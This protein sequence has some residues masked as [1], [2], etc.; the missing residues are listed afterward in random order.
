MSAAKVDL[1]IEKGV[2]FSCTF[3]WLDSDGTATNITSYTAKFTIRS[4]ETGKVI[5]DSSDN[6]TLTLGDAAGT[7]VVALTATETQALDFI[8]GIY[9]L[10][11][12]SNAS[13]PIVTR[14]VEGDVTFSKGATR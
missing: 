7:I 3:T 9:N 1:V 5:A 6:I 12:S 4:T 8:R 13:P 2:T 14:L 11:L 10:E